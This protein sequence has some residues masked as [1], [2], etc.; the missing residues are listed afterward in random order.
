[1]RLPRLG[2]AAA[3]VALA[4]ALPCA[5]RASAEPSFLSKQY[6]RCTSCHVSPTGGGLLSSVRPVVVDRRTLAHR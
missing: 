1:M 3:L 6:T 2:V 4:A 5:S